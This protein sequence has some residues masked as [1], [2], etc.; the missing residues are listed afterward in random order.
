[1]PEPIPNPIEGG[2]T[3]HH[4]TV[5]ERLAKDASYQERSLAT[6][7][8]GK[9]K[10][11]QF[12]DE[13][14]KYVKGQLRKGKFPMDEPLVQSLERIAELCAKEGVPVVF[15]ETPPSD[16]LRKYLP[17]GAYRRYM[18]TVRQTAR[19]RSV[20]WLTLETMGLKFDDSHMRDKAHLNYKGASEL[21][22]ALA[23]HAVIPKLKDPAAQ[24]EADR[25]RQRSGAT[26]PSTRPVPGGTHQH[27]NQ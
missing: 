13:V 4:A 24:L 20:P 21:T 5:L 2:H 27:S 10:E 18:D 3:P 12:Q 9:K 15:F 6:R 14:R 25:A 23:R 19:K 26:V 8:R 7:K 1:V 16:V 17:E 11:Q 22:A